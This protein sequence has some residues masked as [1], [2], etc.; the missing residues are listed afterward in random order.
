MKQKLFIFIIILIINS[1][2]MFFKDTN[3][4]AYT[5]EDFSWDDNILILSKYSTNKEYTKIIKFISGKI[6]SSFSLIFIVE[7]SQV[8]NTDIKLATHNLSILKIKGSIIL[9]WKGYASKSLK[10]KYKDKKQEF[11]IIIYNNGSKKKG[12][13][14]INDK[15]DYKSIINKYFKKLNL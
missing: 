11:F 2:S 12:S 10:M 5:L 9:D 6:K 4:H 14:I 3:G 8:K 15:D 1:F 13:F 7:L